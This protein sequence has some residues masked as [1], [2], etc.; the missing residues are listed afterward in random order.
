MSKPLT[1]LTAVLA[2]GSLLSCGGLIGHGT[3]SSESHHAM[4]TSIVPVAMTQ[5]LLSTAH[6]ADND[7]STWDKTPR[8]NQ[9]RTPNREDSAKQAGQW[10][11]DSQSLRDR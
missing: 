8:W 2:A 5:H 6:R 7:D 4:A 3:E 9:T 11:Q 1:G 10:Y